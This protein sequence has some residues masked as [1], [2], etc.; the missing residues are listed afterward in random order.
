MDWVNEILVIRDHLESSG[1]DDLSKK[2]LNAQLQLGTPGEMIL[3]VLNVLED[4]KENEKSAFKI[5]EKQYDNIILYLKN[6]GYY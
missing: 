3:N 6:I 1:Y 4:I 5:I 2:I